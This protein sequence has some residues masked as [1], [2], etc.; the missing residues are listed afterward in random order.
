MTKHTMVTFQLHR[1]GV[2]LIVVMAV[3]VAVLLVAAGYMA[4][5]MRPRRPARPATA[6]IKKPALPPAPKPAPQQE[7]FTL[8]V[9]IAMSEE[10]AAAEVKRLTA[11]KLKAT[12]VP[13]ETSDGTVIYELHVGTYASRSAAAKA[14]AELA[15]DH[16]VEGAVVPAP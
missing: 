4:A 14:A 12:I 3:I 1:K 13:A 2:I 6:T 11:K 5:V 9:A 7:T 8:R 16:G 10:E 15:R